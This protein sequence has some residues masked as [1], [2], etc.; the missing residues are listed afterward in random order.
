MAPECEEHTGINPS[1]A[2]DVYS[3]GVVFDEVASEMGVK[4]DV[5]TIVHK[6]TC[7]MRHAEAR[8]RIS[9]SQAS[10]HIHKVSTLVSD[11][12]C[13]LLILFCRFDFIRFLQQ[14]ERERKPQEK[15]CVM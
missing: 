6:L 5:S 9:P 11:G 10:K 15:S 3:L 1:C 7:K 13:A 8:K 2:S 12:C 4:S 14:R